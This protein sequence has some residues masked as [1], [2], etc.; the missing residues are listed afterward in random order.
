MHAVCAGCE[1]NIEPPV[2]QYPAMSGLGQCDDPASQVEELPVGEVL[3]AN[4]DEIYASVD[5]AAND[6]QECLSAKLSS[7]CDVVQKR[8]TS[9]NSF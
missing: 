1:S 4:L 8:T 5:D 3:F 6:G 2:D 9:R 7:V